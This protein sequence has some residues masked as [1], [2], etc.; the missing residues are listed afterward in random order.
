MRIIAGTQHMK[1]ALALEP[2][3]AAHAGLAPLTAGCAVIRDV[4]T[5]HSGTPNLGPCTRFMPS[6]E[7]APEEYL[8]VLNS[9]IL[10]QGPWGRAGY[11]P[12]RGMPVRIYKQLCHHGKWLCRYLVQ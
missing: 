6:C 11:L 7:Y 8:E 4:R 3:G 1:C 5:W 9:E 2:S 10:E 12:Q